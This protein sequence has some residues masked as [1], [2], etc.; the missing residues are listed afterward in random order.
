M[1]IPYM[2]TK[3]TVLSNPWAHDCPRPFALFAGSCGLRAKRAGQRAPA[4]HSAAHDP[5]AKP[6]RRRPH[7]RTTPASP[8]TATT[9]PNRAQAYYHLALAGVYEDDAISDGRTDEVNKAIEEYKLALNADPNSAELADDLADLYFRVGRVH[10][11]EVTARTLLKNSPND[12]DAHKLLGRIYLRQL[13][14]GEKAAR[15]GRRPAA[16]KIRCWTRRLRSSRR[17][18]PCSRRAWKITW[19]W[20]SFTP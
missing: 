14:E 4:S 19:C 7:P 12:I 18:W 5:P 6:R 11:A 17:L 8:A 15:E 2:M 3:M 10:D 20:G 1:G 9:E 16:R 13:G